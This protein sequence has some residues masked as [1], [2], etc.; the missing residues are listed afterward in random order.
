MEHKL[1]HRLTVVLTVEGQSDLDF[2]STEEAVWRDAHHGGLV[3]V[4][5]WHVLLLS[6]SGA[7]EEGVA[8][9][10]VVWVSDVGEFG[11]INKKFGSSLIW[12]GLWQHVGNLWVCVVAEAVVCI[13]KVDAVERHKDGKACVEVVIG[14]GVAYDS[15]GG[16][17]LRTDD[18]VTDLAEWNNSIFKSLIKPCS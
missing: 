16:V 13:N 17:E 9:L 14:W 6:S 4:D 3:A 10:D 12:A 15:H 11:A 5:G 18:L 8:A 2:L 1:W 7:V